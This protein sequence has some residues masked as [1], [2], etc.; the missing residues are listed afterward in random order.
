[1]SVTDRCIATGLDNENNG[2]QNRHMSIVREGSNRIF[3]ERAN[4][5]KLML[6]ADRTKREIYFLREILAAE[7]P[8]PSTSALAESCPSGV[9]SWNFDEV[10]I[11]KRIRSR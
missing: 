1:M 8:C 4:K 2:I 5:R 7:P 6:H 10:V 9:Q 3:K 11:E